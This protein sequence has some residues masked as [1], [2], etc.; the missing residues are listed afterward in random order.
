MD[1]NYLNLGVRVNS[2]FQRKRAAAD[3][4]NTIDDFSH[5]PNAFNLA[6]I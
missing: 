2:L 3:L 1:E 5:N 6:L 4:F